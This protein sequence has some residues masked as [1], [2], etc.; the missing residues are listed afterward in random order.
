MKLPLPFT[1]HISQDQTL[2]IKSG[3]GGKG[4]LAN[5][6]VK[7]RLTNITFQRI[8]DEQNG[9]CCGCRQAIAHPLVASLPDGLKCD[10]D[11]DPKT[12]IRTDSVHVR[13]LLCRPCNQLLGKL[14]DNELTFRNLA[15]YLKKHG[16]WS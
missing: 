9:K 6:W 15:D 7:Y 16:E 12:E 5:L 4:Y 11:H 2:P 13:G 1:G 8:W 14:H 3:W 10:V